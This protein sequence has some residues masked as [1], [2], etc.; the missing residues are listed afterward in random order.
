MKKKIIEAATKMGFRE[1]QTRTYTG[2]TERIQGSDRMHASPVFN[3]DGYLETAS[4]VTVDGALR[5]IKKFF[6]EAP[7]LEEEH[8]KSFFHK[9]RVRCSLVNSE[10]V[11]GLVNIPWADLFIVFRLE[12]EE[13][14]G[15]VQSIKVTPHLFEQLK[16]KFGIKKEEELLQ[17][18]LKNQR[19]E[20]RC[21]SL[22]GVLTSVTSKYALE[23]YHG[24]E[25]E[26]MV[27]SNASGVNGSGAVLDGAIMKKMAAI[28]HTEKICMLPSS[29]HEW[30]FVNADGK[31]SAQLAELKQMVAEVNATTVDPDEKLSDSV[32]VYMNG[33][34][35]VA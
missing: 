7:L 34:V 14:D 21:N 26:L 2:I 29:I 23:E 1:V 15:A 35:Q 24:E 13:H 30:I 11:H 9:E 10:Q 17:I 20:A 16:K 6:Q 5:E 31:D 28:M 8:V 12:Q 19:K 27:L 4:G 22:L 33:K 32:Y 3:L 18:A 25:N